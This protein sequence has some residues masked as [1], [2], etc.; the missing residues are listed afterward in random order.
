[1]WSSFHPGGE[2]LSA[3]QQSREGSKLLRR[4]DM[5][6]NGVMS[7]SEFGTWFEKTYHSI[8]RSQ[9]RQADKEK[10]YA[11]LD[12][13]GTDKHVGSFSGEN[14]NPMELYKS[15][16]QSAG[17]DSK[18]STGA[19]GHAPRSTGPD[20]CT[21]HADLAKQIGQVQAPIHNCRA[22]KNNVTKDEWLN[23]HG[24]LEQFNE[25]DSNGDGLID[26][27]TG[28]VAKYTRSG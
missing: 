3:D 25:M 18:V 27:R 1:V 14:A 5:N 23:R 22:A 17:S 8:T 11:D 28:L 15:R 10:E 2:P 13:G 9:Q 7:F 19:D 6:S 16:F 26:A 21:P 4:L 12:A 24:S 20:G